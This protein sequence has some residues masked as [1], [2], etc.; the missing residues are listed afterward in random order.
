[1]REPGAYPGPGLY[2]K[3]YGMLYLWFVPDF[4]L[5]S[6]ILMQTWLDIGLQSTNSS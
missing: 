3:F 4:W 2:P 1:M 6:V 5:H